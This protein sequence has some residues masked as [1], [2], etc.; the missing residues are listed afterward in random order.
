[1]SDVVLDLRPFWKKRRF[2]LSLLGVAL[3]NAAVYGAVTYRLATKQE[4]LA[5]EQV[6]LTEEL[7]SRREELGTLEA[8]RE[9]LSNNNEAATEFWDEVVKPRTPGLT[10]AVAEIDRLARST[11]VTRGRTSY[12]GTDLDV[13]LIEIGVNMPLE[14]SYFNLVRF[15]N[16]LERSERFFLVREISLRGSEGG[17]LELGCDVSFFLKPDEEEDTVDSNEAG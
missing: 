7:A 14:G 15:I 12:S 1:M 2:H 4:R 17:Q 3:A 5:R 10:E 13:G 6:S 9:R 11:G 16:R 8:E